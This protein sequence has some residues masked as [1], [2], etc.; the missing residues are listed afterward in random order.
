MDLSFAIRAIKGIR[1]K[2]K[3]VL[4]QPQ[5]CTAI[6]EVILQIIV[7]A[8]FSHTCKRETIFNF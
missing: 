7:N 8:A 1:V 5:K 3:Q 6:T 4:V 2:G